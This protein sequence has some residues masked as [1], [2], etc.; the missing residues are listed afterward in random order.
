MILKDKGEGIYMKSKYSRD[1]GTQSTLE[2]VE[3]RI[4]TYSVFFPS[5]SNISCHYGAINI[6]LN[7]EYHIRASIVMNKALQQIRP[8]SYFSHGIRTLKILSLIHI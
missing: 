2:T 5:N 7:G 1:D 4:F 3:R 6:P 8:F